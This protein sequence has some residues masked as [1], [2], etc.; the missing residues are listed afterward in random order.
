M[1]RGCKIQDPM[2]LGP[3]E[4]WKALGVAIVKQAVWDWKEAVARLNNPDT[5]T[6]EMK[7]QKN[8]A[9]HFLSSSMFEFYSNLD[10]KALLKSMKKIA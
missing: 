1:K 2:F 3:E 10:G 6:R 7:E 5:A 9:E 8:S 4:R